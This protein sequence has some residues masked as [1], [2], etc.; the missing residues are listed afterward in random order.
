M[1]RNSPKQNRITNNIGESEFLG[2][3]NIE[4]EKYEW[5]NVIKFW[6]INQ[7]RKTNSLS[8]QEKQI[9]NM[10]IKDLITINFFL[11]DKNESINFIDLFRSFNYNNLKSI[12]IQVAPN[13]D[14]LNKTFN[15][16]K[17]NQKKFKI[18]NTISKKF[19]FLKVSKHSNSLNHSFI[20]NQRNVS[21][22]YKNINEKKCI[23]IDLK[24]IGSSIITKLG[25]LN[26]IYS[27]RHSVNTTR[28]LLPKKTNDLK[29]Y[30]VNESLISV[31]KV[32]LF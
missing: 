3:K 8:N 27:S 11:K 9:M 29:D 17:Q 1:A 32:F 15:Y 30:S 7:K 21:N 13:S 26:N 31:K 23:N 6:L 4:N 22:F 2:S 18:G 25:K 20:L 28:N 24:G 16:I 5:E 14:K 19:P 10:T 12:N